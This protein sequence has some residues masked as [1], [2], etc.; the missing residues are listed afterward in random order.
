MPHIT[1]DYS[2][3][4]GSRSEIYYRELNHGGGFPL[5]FLHGGWGYDI[6]PLDRQLAMLN[7][8]AVLTP[9]RSGYGR[10]TKPAV[11]GSDFHRRA[12]EETLRFL[13]GLHIDRCLFWGHSDGAVIAAWIGL[14]APERCHGLILES[15][16]YNCQK[17][18]SRAWFEG[19]VFAPESVGDRAREVLAREHGEHYWREL[20]RS[21]GQSWLDIARSC[22]SI[23]GDLYDGRLS[24]LTVRVLIIYGARDPHIEPQERDAVH[25]ELPNASLHVIEAA[26]HSPHSK[27]SSAEECGRIIHD[28][29]L[30]S[31]APDRT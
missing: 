6:Y 18:S 27:S 8:F 21:E 4:A 12:A 7:G 19:M 16:H 13:D 10:S 24:E 9:D 1:L 28:W 30:P 26:G 15:F 23:R 3:L 17:L 5:L 29:L 25:R 2:P 20:I 22:N 11:F 14:V 31:F